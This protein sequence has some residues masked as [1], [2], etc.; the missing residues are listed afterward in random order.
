[1]PPSMRWGHCPTGPDTTG[2]CS[3]LV[4]TWS[5]E[6]LDHCWT[7]LSTALNTLETLLRSIRRW[8]RPHTA[9]VSSG[10]KNKHLSK[11][12]P[13]MSSSMLHFAQQL[14]HFYFVHFIKPFEVNNEQIKHPGWHCHKSKNCFDYPVYQRLLLC[15]PH[16]KLYSSL[17]FT[18]CSGSM[19]RCP[20]GQ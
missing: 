9:N 12:C 10:T 11:W 5:P 20:A 19:Q 18:D 7:A 2:P 1:M 4:L 16:L 3:G 13:H 17:I 14:R 6:W 15:C 8:S